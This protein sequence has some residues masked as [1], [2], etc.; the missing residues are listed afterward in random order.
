M[1]LPHD[2]PVGEPWSDFMYPVLESMDTPATLTLNHYDLTNNKAVATL[3][4]LFIGERFLQTYYLKVVRELS[5][6]FT[7]N[8]TTHAAIASSKLLFYICLFQRH[9]ENSHMK[10]YGLSGPSAFP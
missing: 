7:M 5:A 6:F 2:F 8:A 4:M 1:F 3:D 9:N 10:I